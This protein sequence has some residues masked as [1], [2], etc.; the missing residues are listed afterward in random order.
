MIE[1]IPNIDFKQG[2]LPEVG[3]EIVELAS[4][5]DRILSGNASFADKPHRVNFHN[6]I[7]YT[8][9]I[10]QH[11]V[12]FHTFPVEKGNVVFVHKG[13]VHAFDMINKPQ[14]Q[15]ILVTE[16]YLQRVLSAVDVQVLPPT[17]FLS[18]YLPSYKIKQTTQLILQHLIKVI[19][20]EYQTNIPN[21]AFLQV[22]FAALLTKVEGE[23]PDIYH[24][25]LS[26]FHI[27]CF[28]RFIALLHTE[29]IKRLDAQAYAHKI[30]ASYKTLNKICKL[31]T[32][33]TV[34]QLI[35]A[36]TILEAKRRLLIENMQVQQLA[37]F[38]GFE[39]PTNFI[40]YFK[41]HTLMTPSQFKKIR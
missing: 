23:R 34:K 37:F 7:I 16:T 27:Q 25:Q 12:D 35:D 17:H 30:G 18:S 1:I 22:L 33:M 11:F 28:E 5:Y 4:L 32:N 6:L 24:N 10:G 29:F 9:G 40:K 21:N 41:K 20:D 15:L 36:Y 39:E 26:S 3:F 38:L 14:G 31:A 2:K 8:G 19:S 13:Q